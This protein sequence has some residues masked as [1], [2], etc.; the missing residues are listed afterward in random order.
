MA[1]TGG[2]L[3]AWLARLILLPAR[4]LPYSS[5]LAPPVSQQAAPFSIMVAAAQ[6]A[7]SAA[8]KKLP[9]AVVGSAQG[10]V[11]RGTGDIREGQR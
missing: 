8:A 11:Q 5:R 3:F 4:V 1:E 2:P 6:A 10:S 7:R 9:R